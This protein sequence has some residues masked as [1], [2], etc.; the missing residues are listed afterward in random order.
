MNKIPDI[1]TILGAIQHYSRKEGN[2]LLPAIVFSSTQDTIV[3]NDLL[4]KDMRVQI[5][6]FVNYRCPRE[7][8]ISINNLDIPVFQILQ[9]M[10]FLYLKMFDYY[11]HEDF[12]STFLSEVDLSKLEPMKNYFLEEFIDFLYFGSSEE[13]VEGNYL[14][15]FVKRHKNLL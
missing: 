2:F 10:L 3:K 7:I 13:S 12:F 6:E 5:F 4:D 15:T 9:G 8:A 1:Y 14:T 11:G